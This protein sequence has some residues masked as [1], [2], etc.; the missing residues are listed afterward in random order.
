MLVEIHSRCPCEGWWLDRDDAGEAA[1]R[2]VSETVPW[3][4]FTDGLEIEGWGAGGREGGIQN[5]ASIFSLS[6]KGE[7]YET[8]EKTRLG[9]D[10]LVLF[11]KVNI[12]YGL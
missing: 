7:K 12:H 8:L 5:E 1:L 9:E 10:S 11:G 2:A 4:G 3:T 6:W